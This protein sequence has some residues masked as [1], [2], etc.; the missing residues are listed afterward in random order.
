MGARAIET[1]LR[2]LDAPADQIGPP[3]REVLPVELV[4]RG[5]TAPPPPAVR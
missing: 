4:A 2:Q 1:L 3:V 5:S